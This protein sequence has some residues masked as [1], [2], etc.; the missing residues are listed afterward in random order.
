ME[1]VSSCFPNPNIDT[2][3]E[4]ESDPDDAG[5]TSVMI[6]GKAGQFCLR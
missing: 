2:N 5:E 3:I 6:P 4:S 1:K